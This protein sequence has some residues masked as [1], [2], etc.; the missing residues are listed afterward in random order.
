M[1]QMMQYFA[2]ENA[3]S[4]VA[5]MNFHPGAIKTESAVRV[6]GEGFFIWEDGT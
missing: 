1:N 3:D 6:T 4:D 2:M 5:I